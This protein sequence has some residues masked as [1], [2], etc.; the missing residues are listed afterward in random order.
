[1][2]TNQTPTVWFYDKRLNEDARLIDEIQMVDLFEMYKEEMSSHVLVGVFDR[3]I[4]LEAEFDALEPLCVVPPDDET[5]LGTNDVNMPKEPTSGG[6][7]PTTKSSVA[8]ENPEV[9]AELEE[10]RQPGMF[11]NEEEYVAVD[12]EAMYDPVLPA[13]P[14]EFA[15]TIHNAN[16]YGSE[17]PSDEFVHVEAEWMMLTLWRS[18]YC[19]IL[20]TQK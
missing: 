2:S 7:D 3:S 16:T 13:Q 1:M 19:M 18:M 5:E 6:T 12:D 14:T 15:H 4:C 10:N 9:A 8:P 17:Q 20:T 11:D